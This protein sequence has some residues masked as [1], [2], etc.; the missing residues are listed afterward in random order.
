MHC[1]DKI[2]HKAL[3]DGDAMRI[4]VR[5]GDFKIMDIKILC[6]VESQWDNSTR[7]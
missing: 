3:V 4:T 6:Q 1:K 5:F 2:T 7:M